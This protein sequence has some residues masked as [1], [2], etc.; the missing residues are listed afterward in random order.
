MYILIISGIVSAL[1]GLAL[2]IAGI[3]QCRKRISKDAGF[4]P[5][6]GY[7]TGFESRLASAS[8]DFIPVIVTKEYAP[9]VKY[10][11]EKGEWITSMLPF[12]LKISPEYRDFKKSYEDGAPL[13][14]HYNPENP[15]DCRYGS[16]KA[17]RVREFIYKFIVGAILLL[18]GYALIWSHFNM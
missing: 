9:Y 6:E 7:V 1:L 2:I 12:T 15:T 11:T 8:V 16:K 10:M 17:F 14:V 13:N 18:I 3:R 4:I 5:A